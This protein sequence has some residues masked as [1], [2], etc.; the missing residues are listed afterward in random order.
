MDAPAPRPGDPDPGLLRR[1]VLAVSVLDDVDLEPREGGVHLPGRRPVLVRWTELADVV[2]G[3]DLASE[4]ARR[5][6][7]VLLRLRRFVGELGSRAPAVLEQSAR[8]L[9]LPEGHLDDLGPGWVR[10]TVLG[11]DVR[12]GVGVVGVLGDDEEVVPL[13]RSVAAAAG[14][15]ARQWWRRL[16][17]HA[18]AMGA[19]AAHR[20]ARDEGAGR[21]SVLRPV[22]GCDVPTLLASSAL[23][24]YLAAGDGSGMRAL[25]VPMRS[26]GWYDLARIDPAFV[27]AAWSATPEVERGYPRPLLVTADEVRMAV[28]RGDPVAQSLADPVTDGP[29]LRDVRY[30]TP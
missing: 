18:E 15:D 17:G 12:L 11:G 30:H 14:T 25:A 13:H 1:A 8:A 23:R 3:A 6:I 10:E 2:A 5:R 29:A 28:P 20:L 16:R 4:A 19:L 27:A 21:H 22:G 7:S 24:G 26:R 9:A